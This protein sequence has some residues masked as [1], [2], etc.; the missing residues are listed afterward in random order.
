MVTL[1]WVNTFPFVRGSVGYRK[2]VFLLP[3]PG[4][5]LYTF[6]NTALTL[7]SKEGAPVNGMASAVLF[8]VWPS[9]GILGLCPPENKT[10]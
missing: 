4:S 7:K 5:G 9:S 3:E 8:Q 6:E 1:D 2:W 10:H